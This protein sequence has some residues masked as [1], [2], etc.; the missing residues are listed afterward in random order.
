MM[1]VLLSLIDFAQS[2]ALLKYK[3]AWFLDGINSA[4]VSTINIINASSIKLTYEATVI[5]PETGDFKN[6]SI[7]CTADS[8]IKPAYTSYVLRDTIVFDTILDYS[9]GDERFINPDLKVNDSIL[10]KNVHAYKNIV[11]KDTRVNGKAEVFSYNT[12]CIDDNLKI[13]LVFYSDNKGLII[14]HYRDRTEKGNLSKR[15]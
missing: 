15:Q 6:A 1:F 14:Y 9:K 8:S 3:G 13:E 11:I 7:E 2:N 10:K 4:G 5:D 12:K